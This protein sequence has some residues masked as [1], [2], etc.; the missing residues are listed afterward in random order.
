MSA[1]LV[2]SQQW[3]LPQ[4]PTPLHLE[5]DTTC[6]PAQPLSPPCKSSSSDGVPVQL[7]LIAHHVTPHAVVL[8]NLTLHGRWDHSTL[9]GLLGVQQGAVASN[10]LLLD[11]VWV[12]LY[13]EHLAAN[14]THAQRMPRELIDRICGGPNGSGTFHRKDL[15]SIHNRAFRLRLLFQDGEDRL[16]WLRYLTN[17]RYSHLISGLRQKMLMLVEHKSAWALVAPLQRAPLWGCLVSSHAN[18]VELGH[19]LQTGQ[20]SDSAVPHIR[21]AA[22]A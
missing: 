16:F 15:Q 12:A 14:P 8:H 5:S 7:Q 18:A 2:G 11:L 13:C 20:T 21:A 10:L 9:V 3:L 17:P 19:Y 1:T 6:T 22:T 4:P